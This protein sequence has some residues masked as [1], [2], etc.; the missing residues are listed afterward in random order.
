MNELGQLRG[1]PA[2]VLAEA[3]RL[4]AAYE[5]DRSPLNHLRA[6]IGNL[7][8]YGVNWEH[9]ELNLGLTRGVHHY[10]GLVFEIE[11]GSTG[12]ER[13]LCGGGRY[14]TLVTALGGRKG[15]PAAGFAYG[16][17]R[18]K[19]ALE[20]ERAGAEHK[21]G[22]AVDIL[23]VP[24]GVQDVPDAIAAAEQ[25]RDLGLAV[26]MAIRER[27]VAGNFR[28]ADRR[29][30]PFAAVVGPDERAAS[31]VTLKDLASRTSQQLPVSDVARYIRAARSQ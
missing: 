27:S 23:L 18:I 29:Q 21:A 24:V 15:T 1:E 4:L 2:A 10:T 28:Y 7:G 9:I 14:D 13:Q 25:L 31:V 11:H 12:G 16:L 22:P 20:D 8:Y 5:V 30:I 26:E 3:E 17:E 6:T 19:H